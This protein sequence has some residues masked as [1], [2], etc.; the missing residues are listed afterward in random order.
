MAYVY[1]YKTAENE[2]VYVG[3]TRN[4]KERHNIH[5]RDSWCSDDL[6]LERINADLNDT[7]ADL[8]ETYLINLWRPRE[9]KAKCWTLP[10]IELP[11][12]QWIPVVFCVPS[13]PKKSKIPDTRICARCGTFSTKYSNVEF[14]CEGHGLHVYIGACLCK[15]CAVEAADFYF[16]SLETFF[17]DRTKRMKEAPVYLIPCD[18]LDENLLEVT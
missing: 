7:D 14:S 8:Y 12:V 2:I 15:K 10:A 18:E 17:A 5:K 16:E 9:N 1:R 4:I 3:K 11:D 13:E 6:L